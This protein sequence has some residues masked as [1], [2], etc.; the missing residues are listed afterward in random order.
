MEHKHWVHRVVA[1]GVWVS[2]LVTYLLTIAPT[3]SFWDCGEFITCAYILGVPHPPGAPFYILLG[4]IFSM[5]PLASDIGLRV[6]IISAIATAFTTMLTYLIIV[7]LIRFWRPKLDRL[8]DLLIVYGGSA[9]GALAFAFSET[10]WFNA[11][12]AEVYAISTL[13]TVLVFWLI[14]VWHQHA[15]SPDSD[16][17]IL[18]IAYCIG[19]AIGVHLL[20][21][22]AIPALCF[23]FFSR[24]QMLK[25]RDLLVFITIALGTAFISL[26][27]YIHTKQLLFA[28]I[29]PIVVS[30]A[31][32]RKRHQFPMQFR[33][34]VFSLVA[35]GILGVVYPG[36]VKW[37]PN[38]VLLLSRQFGSRF[39]LIWSFTSVLALLLAIALLIH[40]KKRTLMIILTSLL[41]ILLGA[42]TYTSVY[43]RSQ[44]NPA[45]DEND[46]ETLENL[47]SYINREQYGDWSYV[48]RRAPLWEYQIKK[49]YLRYLFWQ[50]FGKGTIRDAQGLIKETVS[51]R[52][53]WGI[54]FL[55]GM[56]GMFHHFVKDR[57]R[58]IAVLL[59]FLMTGLAIVLYLNQTDPQPRERDYVYVGSFFAFALWIGIG[60]ASGLEALSRKLHG[61]SAD[62]RTALLALAFALL[63]LLVPIK[64]L[65]FNFHQQD[66]S[67]NYVAF[68]YSYNLLQS[69]EPDAILFTN[70]DNDTFPLWFLQYVKQIRRDIR[71]VNLSLLNTPWYIKQLR[72]QEPRVPIS[73]K[74]VEIDQLTPIFWPESR[75][76]KIPVPPEVYQQELQELEHRTEFVKKAKEEPPEII[77]E[78][79]PTFIGK[80]I[81]IQD[82]MVLNIIATNQFRKPIYFAVTVS[83]E[84]MLNLSDYLRMDGLAYKLVT[85]PGQEISP[86]RLR[87]NLCD[88]FQYRN[89]DNPR[90]YYDDSTIGLLMNYRIGFLRLAYFYHREKMHQDLVATLD[91]MQQRI[92]PAII[93]L[94]DPR[95]ALTISGMY[96]DAGHPTKA[97]QII[98]DLL[99]QQPDFMNAYYLLFNIYAETRNHEAGILMARRLLARDPNNAT[100]KFWLSRFESMNQQTQD[101]LHNN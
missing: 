62:R 17:Y 44:L 9:L 21:I 73:L 2:S 26:A 46:P 33:L 32:A 61:L 30:I 82:W 74:D 10:L 56:I 91:A 96:L 53:L 1:F 58:A 78:L 24:N 18:I 69:C 55:L 95:I 43:L 67:G 49:M 38:F 50:Y 13:F 81:R 70:G 16:K 60:C 59:L 12:E 65:A 11:V 36:I 76:I 3:T 77:F 31:I 63:V 8:E 79:G 41:L 71:V 23:I 40:L 98:L 68:D 37:L 15:E 93:P 87:R 48:E 4:R 25:L 100:A 51:W 90:V 45:I 39:V 35:L 42:S 29:I 27:I 57:H 54:P 88:V 85:Y 22:L 72:D 80:A 99:D 14:L 20:N 89:L 47:V 64:M 86:A 97:E 83:R 52:G 6:N 84:S 75:I 7:R 5:I 101:T 94:P 19:L 92:P 34:L 66:R 28:L